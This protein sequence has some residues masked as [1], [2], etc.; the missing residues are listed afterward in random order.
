LIGISDCLLGNDVRYDGGNKGDAFPSEEVEGLFD[1][2]GICP[3]VAIG[4]GVP[5]EPI[6]L[7]GSRDQPRAVGVSDAGRDVTAALAQYAAD[8]AAGVLSDICGYVFTSRSPSCGLDNVPVQVAEQ[9]LPVG[10][11]IFARGVIDALPGLPVEES[12]RLAV[13]G[14]MSSFVDRVFAYAHWRRVADLGLTRERLR[15]FQSR[16][17]LPLRARSP[18]HCEAAAAA[19]ADPDLESAASRY[20]RELMA[21]L[22]TTTHAR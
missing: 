7:V 21:G 8:T 5:R 14:V 13:P 10:R 11:G 9:S 16:Y 17:E 6:R 12:A 1:Y 2:L 3:E 19:L 4:M 22:S 20:L 15:A 18:A